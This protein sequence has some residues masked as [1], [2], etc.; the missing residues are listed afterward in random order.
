[1]TIEGEGYIRA[2]SET[3][4]KEV[5]TVTDPNIIRQAL[6]DILPV[7]PDDPFAPPDPGHPTDHAKRA[8]EVVKNTAL[9]SV[10]IIVLPTLVTFPYIFELN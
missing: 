1:M 6:E 8:A 7:G 4:K 10:A 5:I 3:T 9:T 2:R